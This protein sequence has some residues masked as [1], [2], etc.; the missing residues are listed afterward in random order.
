VKILVTGGA[1]FIG[2]NLVHHLLALGGEV[3]VID[4]LSS[5]EFDYLD[6]RADFRRIDVRDEEFLQAAVAYNPQVI[7]HAAAQS[8]VLKS[9]DDPEYTH[10]VNVEG[11]KMV[12]RAAIEI[13]VERVVFTSTASVYGDPAPELLPVRE[14]TPTAP[15]TPYGLSKVEAE[16][17]LAEM[18]RPAGIDFAIARPS[19]VYGPRQDAVGEGGVVSRFCHSLASGEQ[20][21]LH[22]DGRQT[23]DFIYVGDV[24]SGLVS[25][26]GGEI[27]FAGE[28]GEIGAGVYHLSTGTPTSIEQL[29]RALQRVSG[30]FEDFGYAPAREGDVHDIVLNPGK[31]SEVFEWCA[32]VDFNTGLT[33]T[34]NW[35]LQN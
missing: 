16:A 3:L 5:G 13:G 29:M 19:N 22:S 7:V 2:S 12:A 1:G 11:T 24:V 33:K 23:R 18:L 26:I 25:M 31:A 4:D 15:L 6:P 34:W 27:Y 8:S 17:A 28:A 32:G 20:P 30:K 9:I 14:D 10:S 21:I 35:F